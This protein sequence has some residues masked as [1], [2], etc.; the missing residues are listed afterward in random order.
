M[1]LDILGHFHI[2]AHFSLKNGLKFANLRKLTGLSSVYEK[3]L[4][5][6]DIMSDF[7]G[8]YVGHSSTFSG[9]FRCHKP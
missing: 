6:S 3:L 1:K 4:K 7:Q 5:T 9:H 8:I 2:L